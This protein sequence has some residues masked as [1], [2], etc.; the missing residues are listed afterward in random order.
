MGKLNG[1]G[2]LTHSRRNPLDGSVTDISCRYPV[3]P[4]GGQPVA[5]VSMMLAPNSHACST[6]RLVRSSPLTPRGN[7]R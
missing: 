3:R 2:P 7:P 5:R 1:D 6:A 4:A